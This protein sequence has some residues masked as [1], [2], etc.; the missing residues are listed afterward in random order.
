[1]GRGHI[2]ISKFLTQK[3]SCP[4]EEQ[5]KIKMEQ[6]LKDRRSDDCPTLRSIISVDTKPN[7]V[8]VA[9]RHLL[10]GTWYDC[11]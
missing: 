4:K 3:C 10:T 9:K 5:G 7:T 8:A 11:S 2:A 1:V 6:R